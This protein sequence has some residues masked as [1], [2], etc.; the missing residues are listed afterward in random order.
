MPDLFPLICF[1]VLMQ[2]DEGI[3]S[4]SPAY[5]LENRTTLDY[6]DPMLSFQHLDRFNQKKVLDWCEFWNVKL[7]DE[8]VEY[9]KQV[10][11]EVDI[12]YGI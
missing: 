2:N 6:N 11:S 10:G 12:F 3:K 4:K 1:I 9:Q 7:P 5:I 8:I